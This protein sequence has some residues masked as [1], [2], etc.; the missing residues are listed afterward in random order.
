MRDAKQRLQDWM[1][2][3]ADLIPPQEMP[4]VWLD[5]FKQGLRWTWSG[6]PP[7]HWREF[8]RGSDCLQA[9]PHPL[10]GEV[11]KLANLS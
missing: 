2:Y 11:I 5:H 1:S 3:W 6:N 8:L 9:L 10:R 4:E 7:M